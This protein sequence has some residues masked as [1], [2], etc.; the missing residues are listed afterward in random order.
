M[1]SR[2]SKN[3][4]KRGHVS[5]GHG[6]VG[7]HRKNPGGSGNAGGQHH[8]RINFNKYHPGYF[9]RNGMRQVNQRPHWNHCPT[10]NVEK[11]WSLVPEE[12]RQVAS[13]E[14]VPVI[15]CTKA[16]IFKV[17]GKG[18]IINKPMVVKARFFSK[19]A[20]EKILAAGGVCQLEE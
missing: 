14:Q 18:L 8:K 11:L 3:R 5:A 2:L 1:V 15:D 12:I 6:R 16:G 19:I 4:K 20:E 9:G 13:S 7:K 17:L 10:I